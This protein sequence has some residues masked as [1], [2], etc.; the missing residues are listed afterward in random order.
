MPGLTNGRNTPN[1][2]TASDLRIYLKILNPE[3]QPLGGKVEIDLTARGAKQSLQIKNADASRPI[4]VRLCKPGLYSLTVIPAEG[5]KPV[6]RSI[7]I[8]PQGPVTIE[9]MVDP[10]GASAKSDYQVYGV[11]RDSLQNPLA[12]ATVKAFDQDIR[13]QQPLGKP[14]VS[15][16][17]G[18][19]YIA[20]ARE[21]FATT[22]LLAADVLV[23]VY[24]KDGK[25]LKQSDIYYNA[26]ASLRIDIDL[27]TTPYAGPSEFEQ[28]VSAVTPFIGKITLAELT[29]DQKTQDI[30]FLISKTGLP[31]E[32]VQAVVMAF[33]F[34]KNTQIEAAAFYGLI[35]HGPSTSVLTQPTASSSTTTFDQNSTFT[36]AALM[37]EDIDSLISSLQSAIDANI[38][39]YRVGAELDSIRKLLIAAQQNYLKN[40]PVTASP[41]TLTMKLAIA[42]LQGDQVTAFTS[43]FSATAGTPQDF[44]KTLAQDPSFQAQKVSF[45]QSVF[46]LSQLTGEQVVLTDQ[47]IQA[48]KIQSTG[49]LSKLAANTSQDWQVILQEHKIQPPVGIPGANDADKLSNYATE[50]EQNFTNAFPTPAFTARIKG[51]NQSKIPNAA[52][53][54][55]FLDANPGFDLLNTR[56]GAYLAKSN[57]AKP[58]QIGGTSQTGLGNQL[59]KT[60]RIFK[61]APDYSSANV[62]L[63]DDIDSAHKVYRMGQNNFVA[64]YGPTMGS[65][66]AERV[67]Q[68]AT[69][70]HALAVALV[71]NLK[72]LSD[73]SHLSVF[74]DYTTLISSAMTTEVPDL[75][76]LFGHADFCECDECNSVYGAAAYLTDILHYLDNR[77]T[78]I[79]CGPGTNAS[80]KEALLRRRPDLADIDL[81]CDNTNTTF[82]YIDIANEIMEDFI[83]PPAITVASVFLPKLV[84][85]PIDAGL[86]AAIVAQFQAAGQG[87][88]ASLLTTAATVSTVYSMERL[89]N[90]NTC[91]TENH[92]II[93][94]QFVVL[95]A[96]DQGAAIGIQLLHQTLLSSD[97]INANPEYVNIPAYNLLSADLRPFSLPFDLFETEG[98]LY[99]TKLGTAKPDLIDAFRA[100][101]Q[102][103][104]APSNAT[105]SDLDMA[106]AYL[107]VNQAERKLIFQ[108][109]PANQSLYWGALAAGTSA[110]L[111]LFLNVTGLS[112]S[113]VLDLLTLKSI[114]PVQDSMIVND[115][116]TCDTNK[117]HVSNLTPTKYDMIHRF[118]RLWKKTSFTLEELDAIV[119]APALGNG[120]ITPDLAWKLQYFIQ[121]TNLWSFSA[122]QY[123]AFFQN[124][125]T[126]SADNLY[127]SLFQNR[128]VSN[129]L[130]PDF[131]IASVT[132]L[133]PPPPAISAVHQGLLIGV[134]GLTPADLATLIAKTDGLLSLSNISY[135]YRVAQLAQALS[136]SI[137]DLLV[138]LDIINISPFSDPVTTSKFYSKWRTVIA[139]QFTADDL[140]YLLRHQNDSSGSLISSDDLVATALGDLQGKILATQSATAV[141]PDP[142][143]QLLKKWLTDPLLNWNPALLT[144]LMDMLSTQDDGTFQQKVDNNQTFLLN[145]RVQ[146][147][148]QMLT[149]DLPALPPGL[150][151]PDSLA[152]QI[153][154]DQA[155]LT[156]NFIGYMS[157]GDQALLNTLSGDL[158]YQGAVTKLF[159]AAQL[160]SAPS[161]IIFANVAAINTNLRVLLSTQIPARYQLFLTAISPAYNTLLQQSGVQ[162][163][164]C[165]W[166]KV[167]KDV[168][169]AIEASQPGIYTDLTAAAFIGKKQQLTATNYPNQ[170]NWYQK[171]AKVCFVV[172]ML[173]LTATDVT[174]FLAH[175]ADIGSLDL[176]NLP[177]APVSG[178]I[179]T[180]P[181]FEV[182]VNVLKFEQFFPAVS[183]VTVAATQTISVFTVIEDAINA[184]P[185]ATIEADI[186]TLTG[187]DPTQLDQLINAPANYLNLTLAPSDLKDIRILLRLRQCFLVM[188]SLRAAAA[189]CVAWIKPSLTYEDAV[190]I[191]QALKARYPQDQW[192]GVTQP[193]QNQ[194]RQ[195]KRDALVAHLLA[196]PPAGQNWQTSDD[197]YNYLLIDVEMMAC[198]PT[199]RIVQA[200]N[201]VQQFVQR[202]FLNLEANIAVDLALDADWSQ[203]QWMKYY[204]LWQANREVFLYPE[205]WIEPE[206]LPSEIKSPFFADLE[207]DLLQNDVTQDNVE[208]AFLT[209]LDKLD[210]VSRLEIK[211]MWYD[212][213]AQTLHVVGRTYGGDPK[214]YYYRQLIE[215]RRWTPW[216]A[217]D[218]DIA[219]DHIVLTVFNHRI[220]LFWAAFSEKSAEVTDV[221]LPDTSQSSMKIDKP[222]KYWQIQM[223]FSEYK[224]GKW[225]PKKVSS[226]DVTGSLPVSQ[227]W[228]DTQ[229]DPIT[230][231]SG[232]YVPAKTDFVFTPLDIPSISFTKSLIPDGKPKDPKTFLSAVLSGLANSLTANGDLQINCYLQ[233]GA[234][235][236]AYRGTFDLDPCKGYPVITWN[237]EN[238]VTTLFD[239]SLL[240]NMLDT[241]QEDSS[242]DELAVKSVP[243]LDD[244]PGTFANLVSLQMGFL[245]RLINIIYQ[246]IY[247]IYYAPANNSAKFV[248]ERRIPV[249]VGTFMPYFYQD[250]SRTYFAQPEISDGADFEFT[251][252]DLEDLFL[253][254]LEGDSTKLHEI[255][256]TFPR[257]KPLYLLV[258]FYNAYHPLVCSFMRILFDQGIDALMARQTQLQ[259]DVIF[260]N[261][262][263]QFDFAQVYQPT[264][265]IY[266]GAPVTYTGPGG[267][268]TDA[269]PGYPKADV[270]FDP[271]DSY[272]LYN[273]ELF[274]HAPLMIAERL[275]QNLQFED[276]DHWFKYIFNPTDGSPYPSPD[277]YWVT[278]P[279][280][281]NVND[282]YVQQDI[283]NIMLG[284]D[285]NDSSLVADVTD[286]RNNP[287]QP[288]Y[289]AQ[290]RTVAYQKT[291]VMKYLDHLIA[292]GDNLYQQDTMETVMEAEQLYVLA[293]QILGPRPLVIPPSFATP[294]DNFGQLEQNLDAFSN[295]MVDI[296]NLLPLQQVAGFSGSGG[297]SIPALQTLY[298][299]VPPNDQLM[300]YWDTVAGRLSNI[301]HCLTL[302]GQF[303]PLALFAPKI[304]PGL[305]VRAAAAGLDIGSI[306]ADM[307]SPLPNYR[308]NVMVQKTIEF[309]NEV[310]SLGAALLQAME[311][312]DAEDM[313]LLRSSN[314]IAVLKAMLLVKQQQVDEATHNLE[315]LQQQQA[316]VQTK[317]DYY[318]GLI[319]SGLNSWETTSLALSQTAIAGDTAAVQIE[320]L[321][322]VLGLIPDFDVGAEGFGGSPAATVKFG[323]TQLGGATRAIAA[324]IRG[325]AGVAHSQ[326]G[327]ASTQATFTRRSQEWQFQLSL[328]NAE[329]QQ[330]SKQILAATVRQS[331]ANQDVTNQQL[332]I[333]NAQAEDDFIHSKFTNSDLYAYMIGQISTTYFQSYQLAYAL[334]KQTEQTF[335]YELGLATSSYINFGYWNSLK[336]GLL[337]GEQLTYDVRNM[338]KAYHDQNVRE[339]ELTKQICLSQLDA[340]ALEALITNRECWIN[341]P[342]ELFDMDYPGHYMRRVK[343]MSLTIP[344][345]AG[346]YTTVACTLTMIKNSVRANNTSGGLYPR[347]VVSGIPADDSRFR[348]AVGSIQSI[349]TST[350]QNDDGLFELNFRDERYLPF[351][352]SGAISQWHLQL[353]PGVATFDLNTIS[354]V[355]L[356]LRYTARDGGDG[357]RSDAVASLKARINTMLVSLTDTGLTRLFSSRHEF[358]TE[359]YAFLNGPAGID[360]VLTL[361]LTRDR[362][363]YFAAVAPAVKIKSIELVADTT[364]APINSIV[365]APAPLNPPP[366]N[367]TKDG[368]YGPM[369]R[370]ILDYTASTKDCG[371]WTITNPKANPALTSAQLSDIVAIVHYDVSLA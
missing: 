10:A 73:A 97:E 198:Q 160:S 233:D 104:V 20:Y 153:S 296:E 87:N 174:W 254:I 149:A 354:D 3:R 371:T 184:V 217:I 321:G 170:F 100:E 320:Y 116:L 215:D 265:L 369:L 172:S 304:D 192:L 119:Q 74:P 284:I 359:W 161:N 114:N 318:N 4:E 188:T 288:H 262:A 350:A 113:Q 64:K 214:N 118:L 75:D 131:S 18:A 51:D 345:V 85:G 57:S 330:V 190:K 152:A 242:N 314:G 55:A 348:D 31:R 309:C 177:I 129:P 367:F 168:A 127:D 81:N 163:E 331:I 135:F 42:G 236:Y 92:W 98:E 125:D 187:W 300:A 101:H 167:N 199:S 7:T 89:Q 8:P 301:R 77:V 353:T 143:G 183:Q 208:T 178:T 121:L 368:K 99:L 138:I 93:R 179:T 364:L 141:L 11:V 274:F 287:F 176:W 182:L 39:P 140:N 352:G 103:A 343:A 257:G 342:E 244:T 9:V 110:E 253:A 259:G 234:N 166:F 124:L 142:T 14:A 122:F 79:A 147:Q 271:K 250:Q 303:A 195:A 279:F 341:L 2:G 252:Q 226:G 222:P 41:S 347:K 185:I 361:N 258:H 193:I 49:D 144:K 325:T 273:W 315:A 13:N 126:T 86:C 72:S 194:L 362:F 6:S 305:L 22:D 366:L 47:L 27:S 260:D 162:N 171:I 218:Q 180:F 360:Q 209:Y 213:S 139:N 94:D 1:T 230:G 311:K 24:D 286:W 334:A 280:F 336:K 308:F 281:E 248:N 38:V 329:L 235:S 307:N 26:P 297:E 33:R 159:Q 221:T 12:G 65:A 295:A 283:N 351:E 210:G 54:A 219:S 32:Q 83:V 317:I 15:E 173:K 95:K 228:D 312:K 82:P 339:Y 328:A 40:N 294:V 50:L 23:S 225:T 289:I 117:K 243:Y 84:Q 44:W 241:E 212:D 88:V 251:Y 316:L 357:L 276:A 327:V 313:A 106:Y 291:T 46:T 302:G 338:E 68:K 169:L 148:A 146:Y 211:A 158:N 37:R 269:S 196:N 136:I 91:V 66:S 112:Y 108:A 247:G 231:N 197:L 109:D 285:A 67:Y 62:L 270:D 229:S 365:A 111:D 263:N 203:W 249:T 200:T 310:K 261:S 61:L 71:G 165:G 150:V 175:P 326:A 78:S 370:L 275:S 324:A 277:K 202:C 25:L 115:D 76:T 205:N 232:A 53:I 189:D 59:K 60:Q 322:N 186:V 128:D 298:F 21:D 306:L 43:L 120:A 123:L 134:L 340:S 223:A 278:K 154:Y 35:Q 266:K 137:G 96:T 63:G 132:S 105:Q 358:P 245:D 201:S 16:A 80:V 268:V 164:I 5:F 36:F 151:F 272:S 363:P 107:K 349:A 45:L 267:P 356:H 56:I 133:A 256:A 220:Y 344:C 145:L 224:N 28:V 181:S 299:C 157:A 282:K 156:L 355:I 206:L 239:R 240:V 52:G 293:N 264:P 246:M 19:Y 102:A 346:P 204:R 335:R 34:E 207:S 58:D 337:A 290:Y 69:Q 130:N 319:N 29:E 292:W 332:Q 17:S 323:G 333:D 155:A 48:E 255:L 90:D 191:T 238:L 70:T 216:I 227:T 30:T 237:P